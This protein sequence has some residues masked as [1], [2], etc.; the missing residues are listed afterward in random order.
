MLKKGLFVV[1]D[2]PDGVGKTTLIKALAEKLRIKGI[3][4]CLTK[5]VTQGPIGSLIN[6]EEF[7]GII[8]AELVAAD[9]LYHIKNVIV[10]ALDNG[11]I[12]ISD[13][14]IASSYVYQ[15]LDGVPLEFIQ[16]L[17][18][19]FIYPEIYVFVSADKEIIAERLMKR[20]YLS[21]M[22]KSLYGEVVEKYNEVIELFKKENRSC[23]IEVR[24]NNKDDLSDNVDIIFNRL[25]EYKGENI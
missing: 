16:M 8:L 18:S 17:N 3:S 15:Q 19:S 2:G 1:V 4:A 6:E 13:R 10:P 25:L 20:D 14:Y 24:N 9:R 5:E 23:V 21:R 7:E 12:V 11:E 22:E